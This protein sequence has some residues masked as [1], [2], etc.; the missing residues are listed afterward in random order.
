MTEI[1]NN[2]YKDALKYAANICS[3]SE[4]CIFDIES[5]L[6]LRE[7]DEVDIKKIIE[8]L[9]SQNYIDE[10]RFAKYYARD[11]FKFQKWGKI[12]IKAMLK[13]KKISNS[14][15]NLGLIEINDDIYEKVLEEIIGKKLK[16]LKFTEEYD[17]NVKIIRFALSK[18]F[19]NE[20]ILSILKKF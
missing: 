2:K 4:K 17:R 12:K 7:L 11:K 15:I 13:A 1:E 6:K 9:V 14:N 16:T 10:A 3:K 20:I 19:E 18:G 5:K 8:I